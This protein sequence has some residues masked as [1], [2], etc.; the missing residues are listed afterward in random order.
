MHALAR[1]GEWRLACEG[2]GVLARTLLTRGRLAEADA[3]LDGARQ[4]ATQA[5][6]LGALQELAIIRAGVRTESGRLSEAEAVLE[7]VL[8]SAASAGTGLTVE[9]TLAMV[10]CLNWQGRYTEAFQRLALVHPEAD[11]LPRDA[12]RLRVARS[13]TWLGRGRAAEAVADAA[14][15][16][17]AAVQL[18]DPALSGAAL[19]ACALAQLAAGDSV[20]GDAAAALAVGAARRAH[21][22]LLAIRG[23][24]LRAEIARRQGQRGPATLLVRRM[25]KVK[26]STLPATVRARIDLLRDALSAADPIEAAERRADATGLFALRLFAPLRPSSTQWAAPAADDIVELMRCCQVAEED[27]AVL[28]AVCAR[29]RVRLQ[30]AG[31]AFFGLDRSEVVSVAGDGAKLEAGSARRILTANQLVLP[32]HGGE[33]VEAG[34]PVRYAGQVVGVL[35]ATWTAASTW[36]AADVSVLL[37]TGATAAGPAVSAGGQAASRPGSRVHRSC[38]AS[39]PRSRRSGPSIE[40][41]AAAPFAALVK[42]ESGSGKELAARMLHKLGP[43]ADR[44]FC[45][46]NCAAL[47]AISSN[48]NC[49]VMRVEP[50]PAR[51][52]NGAGVFEEAQ[53]G[54][55][56]PRRNRRAVAS[57]TSQAAARHSGGRV[58]AG[59]GR[60]VCRRVDVRLVTATNRDLRA[61]AAS[62]RLP[63]RPAVSARRRPPIALPPLRLPPALTSRYWRNTSGAKRPSGL[64]S[65]ATLASATLARTCTVRLAGEHSRTAE[66]ARLSG[67]AVPQARC[68]A[69]LG[70]AAAVRRAPAGWLLQ[71]RVGETHVRLIVLSCAAPRARRR[72]T[73]ARGGGTRRVEAGPPLN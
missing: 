55:T 1:R 50:S 39:Y 36:L 70:P 6:E 53:T 42:G 2:A 14:H 12:V 24:V 11:V 5:R 44:P 71:A 22:P 3:V 46:L 72:T 58:S 32:H 73:V 8:A 66:R 67:R 23:R 49:S 68:R 51:L 60:T 29:L 30:A 69:A 19:Y 62:G 17:D 7:T 13:R 40:K 31:V 43:C 41:A 48:R 59:S 52:V 26:S 57:S 54:H 10:R 18:D 15:A 64:G 4:W 9:A 16:R 47:P 37:S 65:R 34:V 28:A 33:R 45:T 56:L 27:T 61:E 35:V 38:S 63:D 25:D 21:D 20:Q